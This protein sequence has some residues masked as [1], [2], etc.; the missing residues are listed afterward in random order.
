MSSTAAHVA[1]I[2][3]G[4]SATPTT[5]ATGLKSS[6]WPLQKDSLDTTVFSGGAYRTSITGLLGFDVTLSGDHDPSDTSQALLRSSFVSGATVYVRYLPDGTNGF[7]AG[8]KVTGMKV[9]SEVAGLN[10]VQFTLKST[11][12]LT[13]V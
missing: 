9:S 12:D 10:S 7:E 6:D 5:E 13:I 8:F 3:I 1:V 4:A 11:T 2:K